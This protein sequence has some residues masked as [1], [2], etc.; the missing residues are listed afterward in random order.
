[1]KEETLKDTINHLAHENADLKTTVGK[2]RY[3]G[4][5]SVG[6]TGVPGSQ[7]RDEPPAK[8]QSAEKQCPLEEDLPPV[9]ANSPAAQV[10]TPGGVED[11]IEENNDPYVMV[12]ESASEDDVT[13]EVEWNTEEVIILCSA[14]TK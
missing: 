2:M 14:S 8:Q 5:Q 3:S 12:I 4:M 1:M 11:E 6:Q 13:V 10:V 7:P 9:E